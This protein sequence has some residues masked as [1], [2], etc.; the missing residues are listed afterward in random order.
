MPLKYSIQLYIFSLLMT[1]SQSTTKHPVQFSSCLN[2]SISTEFFEGK[3]VILDFWQTWCGPCIASF[4]ETNELMSLFSEEE[5]VFANITDEVDKMDR[6][7]KILQAYPFNGYQLMDDNHRTLRHF[8]VTEFPTVL[9]LNPKGD[10]IWK[11]HPGELN[12]ELIEIKTGVRSQKDRSSSKTSDVDL[13]IHS[14]DTWVKNTGTSS[15]GKFHLLSNNITNIL[16]FTYSI[17]NSRQ[18]TK[19]RIFS[20]DPNFEYFGIDMS[21]K[22][23]PDLMSSEEFI[24]LIEEEIQK[25]LDCTISVA[26]VREQLWSLR[27]IDQSVF[28]KHIKNV[29]VLGSIYTDDEYLKIVATPLN[30]I[31]HHLENNIEGDHYFDLDLKDIPENLRNQKFDLKLPL[32][33]FEKLQKKFKKYGL[34]LKRSDTEQVIRKIQVDFNQALPDTYNPNKLLL[35][36]HDKYYKEEFSWLEVVGKWEFFNRGVKV[37]MELYEK[38]DGT[39]EGKVSADGITSKMQNLILKGNSIAFD[40]IH[41]IHLKIWFLNATTA[42]GVLDQTDFIEEITRENNK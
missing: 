7:K 41:G 19:K 27:I 5:L 28:D 22:W 2:K 25:N 20:L 11:G 30:E 32:N 36:Y 24:Q 3:Y 6:V 29:E 1:V 18:F 37:R 33:D 40:L 39:I 34:Q 26:R 38:S 21:G 14:S 15:Q 4:E 13:R 31:I 17:A 23:N 8:K 42:K 10:V 16:D 12:P 35:E 9:I